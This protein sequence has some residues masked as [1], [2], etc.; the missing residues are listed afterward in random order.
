MKKKLTL[1]MIRVNCLKTFIIIIIIMAKL[2]K[3]NQLKSY[4]M[5]HNLMIKISILNTYNKTKS[6][7]RRAAKAANNTSTKRAYPASRY[8]IWTVK[9][10]RLIKYLLMHLKHLV[11]RRL[12]LCLL[13]EFLIEPRMIYRIL[14]RVL[15][16]ILICRAAGWNKR[17]RRIIGMIMYNKINSWREDSAN[18]NNYNMHSRNLFWPKITHKI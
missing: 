16:S 1:T 5:N 18:I 10:V 3:N 9:C 11:V 12:Y 6:P 7:T 2:I 13:I 8:T 4:F 15:L 14:I 17:L